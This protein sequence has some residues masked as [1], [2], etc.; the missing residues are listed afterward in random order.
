MKTLFPNRL[1][2]VIKTA[3]QEETD[4]PALTPRRYLWL[5]VF[6]S[7]IGIGLR[8]WN[9]DGVALWMDEAVTLGLARLPVDSILFDKVDNHPP[10]SFL[11]QHYWMEIAPDA[12]LSRVPSALFGGA[13]LITIMALLHDQVSRPAAI[14]GGALFAFSTAHIFY[15][16][17]VRM[18]AIL[19]LG[20][21]LAL[22][23]GMGLAS[24][25]RHPLRTYSALY[26]IGAVIAIYIHAIGLICM[27]IIGG[28]SLLATYF[29]TRRWDGVKRWL[30]CNI[31]VFVL[32]L[33]WLI[34]IPGASSSFGGL[35]SSIS[36]L[37]A[38]W[39]YRNAIGFPG[40]G[41]I[42]TL[43]D[44]AAIATAAT[45]TFLAFWYRRWALAFTLLGLVIL[46]PAMLIG[47][48]IRQSILS[49]RTMLP[50]ELG[51]V[52]ALAYA[53][54][55]IKPKLVRRSM[56]AVFL[57]TAIAS[58][59]TE[60]S[61]RTKIE[62][63][64]EALDFADV[65]GFDQAPILTCHIYTASAL[66]EEA[67]DRPI[68]FSEKGALLKYKGPEYWQTA[69]QSMN[70]LRTMSQHDIDRYLGGGWIVEGGLATLT[71]ANSE[72]IFLRSY[73]PPEEVAMVEAG[74]TQ[75]GFNSLAELDTNK[76]TGGKV[77]IA[78]PQTVV[79]LYQK[80]P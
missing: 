6:I 29:S 3:F 57:V 66:W 14:V 69:S 43:M 54:C 71:K 2:G 60:I 48:H 37:D 50:A 18:Y 19:L 77:M 47:L 36:I 15:S 53:L 25:K 38:N 44:L 33:P 79:N 30:I 46:Y 49:T 80:T 74:L 75:S 9:L 55:A 51:V 13:T 10:L 20:L 64:R 24:P 1:V 17:D 4:S 16:Q 5:A 56:I 73:C 32:V 12:S 11:V 59:L 41:K 52:I 63:N 31:V 35:G 22:W 40:L 76:M 62:Q 7:F 70:V 65:N 27:A 26:I 72:A 28:A 34:Q 67:P 45:G 78:N 61:N 8:F 23:G 21:T 42:G 68:Y 39:F 58:S